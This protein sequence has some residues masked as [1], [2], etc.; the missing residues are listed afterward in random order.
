VYSEEEVMVAVEAHSVMRAISFPFST[1]WYSS[2]MI[3]ITGLYHLHTKYC[4]G[5]QKH[6]REAELF[7]SVQIIGVFKTVSPLQEILIYQLFF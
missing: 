7:H 4:I 2:S 3:R 5:L 6:D 1:P